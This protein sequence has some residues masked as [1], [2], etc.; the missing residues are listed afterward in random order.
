MHVGAGAFWDGKAV[1]VVI[2]GQLLPI[3]T[4][5]V[6]QSGTNGSSS[7]SIESRVACQ[8]TVKSNSSDFMLSV[9]NARGQWLSEISKG[10]LSEGLVSHSMPLSG[11]SS[12]IHAAVAPLRAAYAVLKSAAQGE[13]GVV[14]DDT[15]TP[16]VFEDILAQE[17]RRLQV[18][19]A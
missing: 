17:W 1:A 13:S 5:P 16:S 19:S 12:H 9:D 7:P 14:A 8:I 11:A 3:S 6:T 15:E 4:P 2:T 10:T 18:V